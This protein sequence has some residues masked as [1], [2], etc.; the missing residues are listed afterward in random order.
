MKTL[1]LL[2]ILTFTTL[3]ISCKK[4]N[5]SI[6]PDSDK[7]K[8]ILSKYFSAATSGFISS[9]EPLTYVLNIPLVTVP[10][11]SILQSLI[12]TDPKVSGKISITNNTILKFTPNTPW[13]ND[14][15]YKIKI[16]LKS[17]GEH[18]SMPIE[19]IIKTVPQDF[20]IQP[21]GY[22][23]RDNN[24][25][26]L[27]LT[28]LT[29]DKVDTEKLKLIFDSDAQN[30]E[31]EREDDYEY[32][33][34]F[35]FKNEVKTSNYIKYNGTKLKVSHKGQVNIMPFV[36][37]EF[38]AVTSYHDVKKEMFF[39]YFSEKINP[40][41]DLYGLVLLDNIPVGYSITNNRLNISTST[42]KKD[43]ISQLVIK[44][45]ITSV[46]DE[47]ISENYN[48]ELQSK[49]EKPEIDFLSD[50]HYFPSD[51]EFKIPI[52]SRN[53]KEVHLMVVEINTENVRHFM[54]WQNLSSSE[55]YNIRMF[56]RPVY[57]EVVSIRG[58]LV[59]ENGW[60]IYGLDLSQKIN[61]NPGSIYHIT[62]G[63]GPEHTT[64]SCAQNLVQ[65]NISTGIPKE[66]YFDYKSDSY[67]NSN[68][69]DGY[70]WMNRENPCSR[71]YYTSNETPSRIFICSD[72]GI[73]SKKAG[74][75]YH[76][77][78]WDL[79]DLSPIKNAELNFYNLQGGLVGN[80][81]TDSDGKTILLSYKSVPSILEVKK[82]N[83][84]TY[85]SLDVNESNSLTEFD[86]EGKNTALET[87]FFVYSDRGFYRPGDSIFISL[88]INK[89]QSQIPIGMPAV[90]KFYNPDN[91]LIQEQ[92]VKIDLEKQLLYGYKLSTDAQAKTG[93]YRYRIDIG[94]SQITK[95]VLVE[96]IKPNIAESKIEFFN[97][98]KNNVYSP[99]L[100]G[101]Y[102]LKYL[103]GLPVAGA[104]VKAKVKAKKI[105]Q[106]FERF[107]DYHFDYV[108]NSLNG[109]NYDLFNLTTDL[110]GQGK[111]KNSINF[112]YFN[113]PFR[114]SIDIDAVLPG[115]GTTKEGNSISVFPLRAYVGL[116][117]A[118]GSYWGGAYSSNDDIK[119]GIAHVND[120][121][122]KIALSH[123]VKYILYRN[124]SSWWMDSYYYG[125][126]GH[127]KDETSWQE[128]KSGKV[129]IN[130]L[131]IISFNKSTFDAGEYKI[132]AI[133]PISNH[134]AEV[135]FIVLN[136]ETGSNSMKPHLAQIETDKEIYLINENIQIKLPEIE[137]GKA[138]ISI[139]AGHKI[140]EQKWFNITKNK[141]T[142]SV[143]SNNDW[144]SHVYIHAT[145]VQP[146]KQNN[147]DL[148]LR[149]YGVQH[150]E[151]KSNISPLTPIINIPKQLES[152]KTYTFEVK[153]AEG[154]E[155]EYT[156]ALI[157]EGLLNLSG[158][159]TPHPQE[160]FSGR[161]PL[162]V[163]TWD[164]YKYLMNFFKGKFAGIISI[165]GDDAYKTDETPEINRYKPVVIH[166]GPYKIKAKGHQKHTITIPNYIGKLRLMVV[167]CSEDNFGQ[168]EQM[169]LVKNPLMI[170]SQ[171]PRA[172]N[173]TDQISI[174]INLIKAEK[175]IASAIISAQATPSLIEGWGQDRTVNFGTKEQAQTLYN[176]K[177]KNTPGVSQI[178]LIAKSGKYSM[179]EETEI[180]VNYPNAYSSDIQRLAIE[181]GKS[182]SISA[183]VK[184]YLDV[185][186]S[187]VTVSGAKTPNITQYAQELISYP[188][189]C[190]EQTTSAGFGQLYL[191][192][193]LNLSS[194]D[195]KRRLDYIKAT[196]E[197][198]ARLQQSSGSFSYWE[199]DY[200]DEYSDI[201]AGNFLIEAQNLDLLGDIKPVFDKWIKRQTS[202]ANNWSL[203]TTSHQYTQNHDIYQQAYRLYI[204]ARSGQPAKSALNR[205]VAQFQGN[206]SIILWFI[207]GAYAY[208]GYDSKA[209][210]YITRAKKTTQTQQDD[211][212]ISYFDY[213]FGTQARD[214]AI[215]VDILAQIGD[216]K[217]MADYYFEMVDLLNESSWVSTQT[218]G[219]AF[220]AIYRFYGKS[221]QSKENI[222]YTLSGVAVPNN[223]ISQPQTSSKK[224]DLPRENMKFTITNTGNTTIYIQHTQRYIDNNLTTKADNSGI[225]M[226]VNYFNKSSQSS[227]IASV[228][229][230]DDII[231]TIQ[232]QNLSAIRNK[233]LAL[234][235][236]IP[237]GL[238]LINP[239]IYSTEALSN[240]QNFHYQDFRDDR[241][242]TFF[243][244]KGNEKKSFNFKAKAAY[245]GDFYWPAISCENMY[246]GDIFAKTEAYR[247]KVE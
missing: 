28:V 172:L 174:P 204:L 213:S 75:D 61:K 210:E 134:V 25:I 150:I 88:M 18:L 47:K 57:N 132:K 240:N 151:I 198:I 161:M 62:M 136:R 108:F 81:I 131:G 14:A 179:Q 197:K 45:G 193:I 39:I 209:K 180:A 19:Y 207:A 46:Y 112:T 129:E 9:A 200:Y 43:K 118:G 80:A 98:D 117:N 154:R 156:L 229:A 84:I 10:D 164:I 159:K 91:T 221:L 106:P 31:V 216:K 96:T 44:K 208:T 205:F 143:K 52:K 139:E 105:F 60:K 185:Y 15:S 168:K 160:H 34:K 219:Y 77:A 113:H 153:E 206:E 100:E 49:S 189:G 157:D 90:L 138:L 237:S 239:R 201:Y 182:G 69:F 148:P 58:G 17:L 11:E 241:V 99:V 146:Y 48:F 211:E 127:Y 7:D 1:Q 243:E 226:T 169:V 36:T 142:V 40:K 101:D 175:S 228:K 29:A 162:L 230:G 184:G 66:T 38:E 72:Y 70:N 83:K 54:A 8:E 65:Y 92:V 6:L 56:G 173:V 53:L 123:N 33:A 63:F 165:G 224:L 115:G 110:K 21:R 244:L 107:K 124:S 4:S 212:L 167:A 155:M 178:K 144:P 12:S 94:D 50:G 3:F 170:Q 116:K 130:G 186:S 68:Y 147:N 177:V 20:S 5:P 119:I 158:F 104:K 225:Q 220:K 26:M 120:R 176:L 86:T 231:I 163:K 196:I 27:T 71:E 242:Y 89:S 64:L 141:S 149:M 238:E 236:K 233:D 22:F 2:A 35:T 246:R 183:K 87:E 171:F 187:F 166:Q 235:L 227:D 32:V 95:S 190:L 74:N 102:T 194:A 30:I 109:N 122:Q 67:Y 51:G 76:V 137:E 140:I 192:K 103:T 125:T 114:A 82:D 234:N 85:L 42:L 97:K 37:S 232:V 59:D 24:E 214:N 188:Y 203:R 41:Q 128:Y 135:T 79:I 223:K 111:I 133:S 78:V 16:N 247:I 13:E 245:K 126:S 23:I 199:N 195:N 181:P 145:I 217:A 55:F 218:K 215:K 222:T 191:D 73:L 121:G 202:L 93:S 152:N